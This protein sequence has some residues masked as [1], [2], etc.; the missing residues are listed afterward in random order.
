MY[1]VFKV[2]R[3]RGKQEKIGTWIFLLLLL[4]MIIHLPPFTSPFPY[5]TIGKTKGNRPGCEE[6]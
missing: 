5:A 2:Q 1:V 6:V 4:Y 3:E